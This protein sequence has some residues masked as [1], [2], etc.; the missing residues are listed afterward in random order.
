VRAPQAQLKPLSLRRLLCACALVALGTLVF[1]ASALAAPVRQLDFENFGLKPPTAPYAER[2]RGQ[3]PQALALDAAGDLWVGGGSAEGANTKDELVI[4]EYDPSGG[5]LTQFSVEAQV[6]TIGS[7]AVDRTSGDIYVTGAERTNQDGTLFSEGIAVFSSGGTFLR[8]IATRPERNCQQTEVAIDN[9]A[10][11]TQGRVYATNGECSAH[12]AVQLFDS[13]GNPVNFTEHASYIHGNEI[14]GNT[15]EEFLGSDGISTD[16]EGNIY[17]S[18]YGTGNGVNEFAPSG[19][20]LRKFTGAEIPGGFQSVQGVAVDPLNGHVLLLD[21]RRVDEFSPTGEF[22]GQPAVTVSEEEGLSAINFDSSGHLY[23]GVGHPSG[24]PFVTGY[25]SA[26]RYLPL[27]VTR[28]LQAT[29]G[30]A[31]P[32]ERNSATLTGV[33]DPNSGA[34]ITSCHFSYV[35][36]AGYAPWADDPYAGAPSS[37][38]APCLD[39]SDHEVGT[40]ANPI[41]A[42]TE[43]HA[44]ITGLSSSTV[45]HYRL[46]L[47]NAEGTA[48]GADRT[49]ETV[50]A[51]TDLETGSATDLTNASA[52]LHGDF[53]AEAGLETKFYFEYG[54][55]LGYGHQTSLATTPG[56]SSETETREVTAEVSGLE[57]GTTYHYRIVAENSHGLTRAANDRSFTTDRSPTIE[58][59]STSDVTAISAVLHA[60]I[61][62]E[63]LPVGNEAECHFE[64]GPT[65]FYG[66][67]APCPAPLSGT[68]SLPVEVEITGLQRGIGYHFRVVASNRWGSVTSEDQRF[69]FFPPSCPNSAIRQQTGS[70]YLP[71]C[72]AYELVSPGNANGTLLFPGGPN[73]GRAT[74]PSRLAFVGAYS[75]LP[76]QNVI[77]TIGDL[78]VATRKSTGWT[79][80]YIGPSGDQEGCVGDPPNDPWSRLEATPL[81]LQNR[82]ITDPG[83][84]RFVDFADGSPASCLS[85]QNGNGD[86][87]GPFAMASNSGYMWGADGSALG[88]ISA[89]FG[90]GQARAALDC[91]LPTDEGSL[92]QTWGECN[93]DVAASGDLSHY[94]FSS[95]LVNYASGGSPAEPGGAYDLDLATGAISRVSD[96]A[97]GGAILPGISGFAQA[98]AQTQAPPTF[99]RFPAVSS[100]GSHILMSN[101][102]SAPLCHLVNAAPCER[103]TDNPLRLYMS[104]DDQPAL[105]VSESEVTHEEVAVHYV[106]MTPDGSKVYFTTAQHLTAESPGH[107][108]SSLYMWSAEKA[109]KGDPP[110][111]LISKANPGSPSG[112]GN[113]GNCDPAEEWT[114]ACGVT[115]FIPSYYAEAAAGKGGNGVSDSPL[116]ANGDIYFYS[117]E[118]LDGDRGIPGQ[119]NLY[120]YRGGQLQFVTSFAPEETCPAHANHAGGTNIF[121]CAPGSTCLTQYPGGAGVGAEYLACSEGPI[122]RMEI[123]PDDGHMAFLTADRVTSYDNTSAAG[124]CR[125]GSFWGYPSDEDQCTEM[126]TYTA[127]DGRIVCDSCNPT[128]LQ[129]ISDVYASQDGLFLTD[130]GRTFFSTAEALVPEDTNEAIDVYE[131]VDGRPRLI[132]PGTGT[133]TPQSA[134]NISALQQASGLVGV[135][136]D[137]TDAYFSTF[138]VLTS[139]DHN[140][141]FLKF[142][143]ARTGGGFLQPTPAQPCAAAEECHGPGTEAP[144][145]PAQGTSAKLSG[146][147]LHRGP[148]RK[149]PKHRRHR[150]H[151]RHAKQRRHASHGGSK[152]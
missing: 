46:S 42:I 143:D 21:G 19:K 67:T 135:S 133:A 4:T 8:R 10:G 149:G 118:Q 83:M 89:Q 12:G 27:G 86:A 127:A 48:K 136:A 151:H 29:T 113:T 18:G 112:A 2:F 7:I 147:N 130:D 73:T 128:G 58:G 20:F 71:D 75:S 41:T 122:A 52:T 126:Y 131:Y 26:N 40:L 139:D 43:V 30:L 70:A 34:D 81:K 14:T 115:T 1:A 50:T 146:G 119:Q 80:T 104:I 132:T 11:P 138:D 31:S 103:F 109:Q 22:L 95:N 101:A 36:D 72:R 90:T 32:I 99:I 107:V 111:T 51:V 37:G 96:L 74:S 35:A 140:G 65:N 63:G 64:Y 68:T 120:D 76:G 60:R 93:S 110:L 85:A 44:P 66:F 61:N 55:S 69:E 105:V 141:N 108:G 77:G 54:T 25:G 9:S 150:K 53:T 125:L 84:N 116:A 144:L 56:A 137:G 124:S 57:P 106:G 6:S 97:K 94:V 102:V 91:P 13:S 5:Y 79:S 114:T 39:S 16:T 3:Q 148:R 129:P 121:Q 134:P 142:Y 17:V 123:T 78:Y 117:P 38:T 82:V 59:I 49:F 100:D 28:V 88:R 62:P 87:T 92:T 24:I 33:A 98:Q 47:T 152:G 145:V 15:T 45:Y 23:L